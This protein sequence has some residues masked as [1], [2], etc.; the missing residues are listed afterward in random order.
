MKFDPNVFSSA[1]DMMQIAESDFHE[2][3]RERAM[4]KVTGPQGGAK[5]RFEEWF[6]SE[7]LDG[8]PTLEI[9]SLGFDAGHAFVHDASHA[10]DIPATDRDAACLP[11]LTD[12]QALATW[13]R[14][15]AARKAY[16]T[17]IIEK[18]PA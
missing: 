11:L 1:E 6:A 13:E 15:K 7:D 4:K 5:A 17:A 2:E 14:L 9:A 16:V 8:L 3:R 10:R 18:V 12:E